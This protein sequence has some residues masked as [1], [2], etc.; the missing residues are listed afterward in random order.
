VL[1]AL[2]PLTEAPQMAITG[3]GTKMTLRL[4]GRAAYPKGFAPVSRVIW[5]E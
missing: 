2:Y 4:A 5:Y 1:A 3:G